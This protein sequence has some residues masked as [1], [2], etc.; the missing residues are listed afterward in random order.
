MFQIIK[1]GDMQEASLATIVSHVNTETRSLTD[2]RDDAVALLKKYRRAGD[3]EGTR[4]LR[5]LAGVIVSIRG[6]FQMPDGR[7]DWRGRSYAYRVYIRDIYTD[8]GC[9]KSEMNTIQAAVRYHLGG[10]LRERLDETTRTEYGFVQESPKE[11]SRSGQASR[12]ATLNALMHRD[13]HGGALLGLTA[14][15][16]VL[17]RIEPES[18]DDMSDREREVAEATLADLERRVEALRKRVNAGK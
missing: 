18:L 11:R 16:A 6:E 8:A 14:A 15:Y 2:L 9:S 1:M 12:A 17:N 4:L 10:V 7:P 13:M 5:D 3:G